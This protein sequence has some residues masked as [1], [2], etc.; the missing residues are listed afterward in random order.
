MLLLVLVARTALGQAQDFR[1]HW[2]PSPIE[3]DQG[4]R[5]SKAVGYEVYVS[6]D[7]GADELMATVENDTTYTLA[8][9]PGVIHRLRVVALDALGNRSVSS[10][11]SDPVYFEE[12]RDSQVPV[13]AEL[14]QNYPNPFNPETRLVYGIP[15]SIAAGDPVRLD[16]YSVD[17]RLVRTMEIDRTP[18]WHEVVWDGTDNGGRNASTGMYVTRLVVGSM[19]ETNK[20]TMLK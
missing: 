15:A 1:F 19:V 20:M 16:I 18:G 2:A 11:W 5:F 13:A 6:R 14:Q 7:G 3:D 12:S 4:T 17:G 9:Q 10:E 8:A